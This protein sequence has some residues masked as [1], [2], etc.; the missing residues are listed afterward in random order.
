MR[1]EDL[2]RSGGFALAPEVR[3]I[4][5]M[6]AATALFGAMDGISKYLVLNYSASFVLWVR[7]LI[8]VPLV[9]AMLFASRGRPPLQA[10]RPLLQIA[11]TAVLVVEMT[12]VMLAFRIMPLAAV[13]AIVAATPLVVT[14]LSVPTL[15]E[16]VGWR[17]WLAVSVGFAGVLLIV[18]PGLGVVQ[19]GALLAVVCAFLFALYNI[20]TRLAARSDPPATSFL[21]QTIWSAVLLSLLG[22]W[23]ATAV[24]PAHWPLFVALGLMGA[25]GHYLLVRA[26]TLVPAVVV[27]P[28]FYMMIVWAAFWGFVLFG[29]VPDAFTIAGAALIVGAGLFAAW[30]EQRLRATDRFP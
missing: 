6:L 7:H 24:E 20:L 8:A 11:R 16:R 27:Q 12:L 26:L 1:R 10:A 19:P 23:F 13:H 2:P 28:I 22:P 9:L 18:R 14:A 15:G 25:L 30:R 29:E 4:L 5:L 21:W 3:G 17:R